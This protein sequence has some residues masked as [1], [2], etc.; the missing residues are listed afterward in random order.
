MDKT[1]SSA[2][3]A[4]DSAN[5][6]LSVWEKTAYSVDCKINP[7][8]FGQKRSASL[9]MVFTTNTSFRS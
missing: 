3:T 7:T 5:V 6:K 9:K 8:L 2:A 4:K 1:A